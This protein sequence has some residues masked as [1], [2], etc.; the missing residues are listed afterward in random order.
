MKKIT[1]ML[2]ILSFSSLTIASDNYSCPAD[3]QL[4]ASCK[5]ATQYGDSRRAVKFLESA[6]VCFQKSPWNF[7][8]TTIVVKSPKGKVTSVV[9]G[10]K[11]EVGDIENYIFAIDNVTMTLGYN[12]IETGTNGYFK[13]F[14]EHSEDSRERS[15]SCEESFSP[16]EQL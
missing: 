16:R 1:L 4:V 6:L 2:L 10:S 8:I 11:T 15:L 12:R 3:F 5:S 9:T 13:I 7:G 14:P